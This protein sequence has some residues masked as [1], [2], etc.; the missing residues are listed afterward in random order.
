MIEVHAES[1]RELK[2][3]LGLEVAEVGELGV[4]LLT[5]TTPVRAANDNE[6]RPPVP[7]V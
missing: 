3:I 2:P 4:L 5:V 1:G 7:A 6:G